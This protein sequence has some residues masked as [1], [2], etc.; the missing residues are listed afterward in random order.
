MSIQHSYDSRIAR[1]DLGKQGA[2]FFEQ[3]LGSSAHCD[4]VTTLCNP[5]ALNYRNQPAE[6]GLEPQTIESVIECLITELFISGC[7][8]W[9]SWW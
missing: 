6:V 3:R 8:I 2:V 9:E 1:L 4:L 7:S 5:Y